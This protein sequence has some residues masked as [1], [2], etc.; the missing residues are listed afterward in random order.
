M[1]RTIKPIPLKSGETI[2]PGASV[3]WVNGKALIS[4][5]GEEKKIGAL[6]AAKAL[7]IDIPDDDMLGEWVVDSVCESVLGETVEPDGIDCHGSPSWLMAFGL[8]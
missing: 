2:E 4:H 8:I 1:G 3:R 7:G 5:N 6:T